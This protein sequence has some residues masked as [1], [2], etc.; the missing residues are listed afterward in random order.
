MYQRLTEMTVGR[1]APALGCTP[2]TVT[3]DKLWYG[4]HV[5]YIN[6]CKTLLLILIAWR[7]GVLPYVA[8]FALGYGALRSFSF[9]V[10]LESSLL[11]T[12]SGLVY[13]LGGVGL[14][15]RYDFPPVVKAL[16]LA[17]CAFSVI[18]FA[19]VETIK[20]PI[21]KSRRKGYKLL[22]LC[23]L[24]AITVAVIILGSS[25][26]GNILC[27]ASICQAVNLLPITEKMIRSFENEK[28]SKENR[29]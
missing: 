26:Y 22:S 10:H 18:A 3:Y 2:G 13:Y 25:P 9:G 17:G 6:A 21:P 11:C 8:V 27:M 4:T 29:V 1:L 28:A 16:L 24:A 20:R 14:S 23:V 19:P 12:L 7:L 5:F 15:L